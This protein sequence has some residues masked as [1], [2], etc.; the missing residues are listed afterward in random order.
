VPGS[1]VRQLQK[2]TPPSNSESFA[3]T[4][5]VPGSGGKASGVQFQAAHISTR[6]PK[7]KNLVADFPFSPKFL[8]VDEERNRPGGQPSP[9]LGCAAR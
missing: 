9:R 5:A 1:G 7:E 4:A 6:K 3:T 8:E 2:E